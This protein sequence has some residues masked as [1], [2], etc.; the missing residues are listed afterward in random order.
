MSVQIFANRNSCLFRKDGDLLI[1]ADVLTWMRNH[2]CGSEI[3]MP[4]EYYSYYWAQ[5]NVAI[6]F[7]WPA[8]HRRQNLRS[9]QIKNWTT[10]WGNFAHWADVLVS[11]PL[12]PASPILFWPPRNHRVWVEVSNYLQ[13]IYKIY[14]R[15]MH[16][17]ASP[18]MLEKKSM[19][20][21]DHV[22]TPREWLPREPR[23]HTQF[24]HALVA[25]YIPY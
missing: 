10:T 7:T 22:R 21:R 5:C 9:F 4:C 16:D 8:T 19:E 11:F 2:R 3:R 12:I 20:A 18:R 17:L 6:S 13:E 24:N 25:C 1:T 15:L 14:E 23:Q